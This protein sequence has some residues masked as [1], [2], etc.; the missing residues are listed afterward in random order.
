MSLLEH[1]PRLGTEDAIRIARELY[2]LRSS[3]QALTSERDQNFLLDTD[4]GRFV[5][6]VANATESRPFLEAQNAALAH[7]S[8]AVPVCP[9]IVPTLDGLEIAELPAGNLVRAVK[10]I[11]GVP[12][13]RVRVRSAT[14]L[15]GVGLMLGRVSAALAT[16]DHAAV[17]RRFH[18][19]L[20]CAW[21]TIQ[22]LLPLV[23]EPEWRGFL[24][25]EIAGI[26]RRQSARMEGLRRAVIHNDANDHNVIVGGGTDLFTRNQEVRGLIDF[27]DMV[28]SVTAADPAVAIAYAV[29]DRPNPLAVASL[30]VEGFHQSYPLHHDECAALIDL[31][32]LRLCLSACIAASQQRQRPDD[33]YLAIS[34]GPIR[35][36]LPVLSRIPPA[37]AE[38]TFRRACGFV[39][40]PHAARV[41]RWLTERSNGCVSLVGDQPLD[42]PAGRGRVVALDLGVGSPLV[43]GDPAGNHAEAL[44]ARVSQ[45]VRQ[46]GANVG[47]GRYLETRLLYSSPLFDDAGAGE[48][49][50]TVHLGVDL[51]VPAGTPV[52]APIEGVV[53]AWADNRAPLDY[54]PVIILRHATGSGAEFFTLYGHL[55]RESLHGLH[56]G[57]PVAAGDAFAAVGMA[58]VNGGWAPHLHVQLVTDLMGLGCGFP[59]VC[60]WTEIETWRTFSP[61]PNLLLRLPD[62]MVHAPSPAVGDTLARRRAR[63]ARNLS[64]GYREPLKVVRGW[65]QFLF[66]HTGRRLL[67]AYNNVP[68]VGHSHPDVVRAAEAQMRVLNTNTRYLHDALHEFAECLTSTLPEPLRICYFVNSGSEANELALRL[69]R[70]RT[71]R[72]DLVVLDAAYHG[73]TTTLID[74]SPYKFNGPGGRGRVPWVHIAPLPDVFRGPYKQDDPAAGRRYASHVGE[75]VRELVHAGSPPAAFIAETCPS[76]AGQIMLPAGYLQEVYA[77]VREAG[78]VCIA[79]EVQ[80]AYGRLGSAFYAFEDHQVVPD[81]VVLGKPIGNGHPLGAVITTESIAASF[82]NGMEFFSTFGGNTVSSVVGRAV[83]DV[84]RRERLQQHAARVGAHLRRLLQSLGARHEL[85]GDVRGSGL[86]LGVELVTDRLTLSPARAEAD[87]VVNRMRDRGVLIGSDGPFHNVLKIRPPMP[88]DERDADL[89]A[90]VLD[91]VLMELTD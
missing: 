58:D 67:D 45:V 25:A 1:A 6:K 51:F 14:L 31:I 61:N 16:F 84:V 87:Y 52:R 56:E 33:E 64:V 57:R 46:A 39:P 3:A 10:W 38:A 13:A 30:L 17:H 62:A 59:G 71:G 88:F 85:V 49:R 54:G 11:D 90:A 34:Q 7:V 23:D 81:I 48:E 75:I 24:E 72:R 77:H 83:L 79:D 73:N 15:Q 82:D 12:F 53:H 47:I 76:V 55:T 91:E 50:R 22:G 26:E 35:R 43:S 74:I 19:D 20:S 68:H 86:F 27:G 65:K 21:D 69:A 5:L 78:G 37:I 44:A 2:G 9:E 32:K 36:T 29:L 63:S 80:T 70:A 41:V 8:R 42:Q 18:W 60:R 28:H 4:A 66:E 40:A 89:L